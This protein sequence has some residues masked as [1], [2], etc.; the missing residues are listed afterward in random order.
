MQSNQ[1]E[2]RKRT[3]RFLE[4]LRAGLGAAGVTAALTEAFMA[5]LGT[6]LGSAFSFGVLS[7]ALVG[8][9]SLIAFVLASTVFELP[10]DA[11]HSNAAQREADK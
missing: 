3:Y 7:T 1:S 2:S 9:L 6:A 10:D 5:F 4:K 8:I 11:E